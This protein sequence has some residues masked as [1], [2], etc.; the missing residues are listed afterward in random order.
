[1]AQIILCDSTEVYNI[2]NQ[3]CPVSRLA[4]PNYLCL[5]DAR[6]KEEY[7]ES[8]IITARKAKLDT[9]GKFLI[10]ADVEIECMRYCVVYDSSTSFLL[11]SG[12]AMDC[13]EVLAKSCF[14]P[15]WILKGGY[16]LFSALYPFMRTQKILYTILELESLMPYPV[17]ILPGQ[18]Y[19]GDYRQAT[20]LQIHKDLKLS[21][22]VNVSEEMSEIFETCHCRVL[23][24]PVADSAE[25]NLIGS[26]ERVCIFI[27]SYINAGSSVLIFSSRGVSRCSAVTMAFLLHQMKFTLKEAWALVLRCKT[28]MR[29]NRGFVQQLSDW[30]LCTLGVRKTSI[31]EPNY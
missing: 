1:M 22:I 8:H 25:A 5:I 20:S 27:G 7:N 30:E 16:E 21:A 9:E 4:E 26:F 19:M 11:G 14:C 15:V 3:Y 6:S 13:A 24:I 29:P 17:E 23:H 10:P 12:P 28:N 2:L 18:L 31:A